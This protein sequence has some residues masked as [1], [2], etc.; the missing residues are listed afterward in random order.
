MKS[1]EVDGL[2]FKPYLSQEEL[3]PHIARVA[4]EIIADVGDRDPLFVCILN[5]AFMF[6]SDIAHLLDKPYEMTFAKYSSYSGMHST[7]RLTEVIAPQIDVMGRV[8]VV[9]EDLVDTGF[10]LT[11]IKKLY[12]SRGAEEVRIA[13]ML[14]KPNAHKDTS[15]VLDYVGKE[16]PDDFIVGHGLDY[17]GFGRMLNDIFVV[18]EESLRK[19]NQS[20]NI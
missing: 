15:L 17:N 19:K 8:V 3:H 13:V 10:T 16:I 1:I 14:D 4:K 20:L 2:T 18:D 12:L 5:G 11:E 7:G 6:G 9:L